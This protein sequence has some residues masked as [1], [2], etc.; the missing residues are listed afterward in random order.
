MRVRLRLAY[1]ET[2]AKA[3]QSV[4]YLE[5]DWTELG[6]DVERVDIAELAPALHLRNVT[7]EKV[8]S[9]ISS[10]HVG[11]ILS[12]VEG[13]CHAAVEYLLCGL[14]VVSTPSFGGRDEFFD[15]YGSL[16]CPAD[17]N[18]VFSA[19][20]AMKFLVA[21]G[22]VRAA[23]IRRRAIAKIQDFLT[24]AVNS[25]QSK[26]DLVGSTIP[27]R[28]V[29]LARIRLDNKLKTARNRFIQGVSC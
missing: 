14:P 8:C 10:S 11:L 17:E 12:E 7:R 21:S 15:N 27:A 26:A 5:Y 24:T 20:E 13:Q 23:E 25:F 28:E 3:I 9:V 6:G 19:V 16:I 4:A 29:A 1:P 18:A 2:V 22:E